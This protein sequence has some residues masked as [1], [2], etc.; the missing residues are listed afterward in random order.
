MRWRHV[1]SFRTGGN[2]TDAFRCAFAFFL[3][4]L[5]HGITRPEGLQREVLALKPIGN[6][7]V[8][9][10]AGSGK[11]TMAIHRAAFL[12]DQRTDHQGR[13]LL[14]TFNKS[15]VTYLEH[16]RPPELENVD[17]VNYHRFARGYLS[18]QGLMSR[19]D[20]CSDKER[21]KLIVQAVHRVAARHEDVSLFVR[22]S[23]FFSDEIQWMNQHGIEDLQEYVR[24]ER[25]GRA[26]ARV[27]RAQRPAMY[28]VLTEYH[29]LRDA[30]GRSYDWDDLAGARFGGS[31]RRTILLGAT[32]M[33]SST[34][35]KT[36]RHK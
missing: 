36:F 7:V 31:C 18:S 17:V 28:E 8:L 23:T 20:V 16:L 9:G 15:L 13:T 10:T 25:V 6:I 29:S 35:V 3:R 1:E 21:K 14:T 26:N 5:P 33:S 24:R 11:T 4:E 30:S 2:L 32:G 34:R 27:T 12:A 19:N 22:P